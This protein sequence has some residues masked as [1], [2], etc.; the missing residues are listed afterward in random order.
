MRR[1]LRSLD[2]EIRRWRQRAERVQVLHLREDEAGG[3]RAYGMRHASSLSRLKMAF[4]FLWLRTE[5]SRGKEP[6]AMD[7]A[8]LAATTALFS[9]D[10]TQAAV[11]SEADDK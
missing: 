3:R 5:P 9:E 11:I 6:G 4:E 1:V 8:A 7:E 2:F 10:L